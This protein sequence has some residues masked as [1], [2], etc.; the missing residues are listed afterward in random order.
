MRL[1]RFAALLVLATG[2]LDRPLVESSPQTSNEFVSQVEQSAVNK[3][4][5]LFMV[6][7]S[8]SMAD[9][10]EILQSAVPV[11]V[12]RLTSPLCVDNV[13]GAP[14]GENSSL[15]TCKLGT[16]EFQPVTDIHVGIVTSSLGAHGG[17]V[18]PAAAGNTPNDRA[19][20][21]PTVRAAGSNAD[22]T[23]T[24]DV[25]N[26]WNN[27][28]FLAWDESQH[29]VP[30][31]T[32]DADVFKGKFQD[33]IAASGEHGCG[34][35]ASLE[36]WYRFLIDPE[37]PLNVSTTTTLPEQTVR[38]SSLV[39]NPDGSTTCNGCDLEL[40]AQRKAFL[41]PDSLV[42]IVMLSDEN[43]CSM[44]DDGSA[45]FVATQTD[46]KGLPVRMPKASAACATDPNDP[47]CRS[48]VSGET[49][50]PK[51][52]SALSEDAVCKNVPAGQRYATWDK[53]GDSINLR[54]FQQM[55]RF[56]FDLLYPTSRY[57]D[58][59]TKPM[60]TLQ[61]DGKTSVPNPLY[62][63][64]PG[65]G[66]RDAS[67]VFLAGIV[68]V[69]WQDIA[70]DASLK[71]PGLKYLSANELVAKDRWAVLLGDPAARPPAPPADPFMV[72]STA[73]RSGM[74]PITHDAIVPASATSPTASPINGHEQN[75][76]LADDLQYACTFA[77]QTPKVCPAGDTACDCAASP[78]GDAS[79]VILANSPLC[80]PAAGGAATSEQRFAKAYPGTRELQVLKGLNDHGI[81]A[82]I[83]PK[84]TAS[85]DPA[86]DPNYG[87]NPAV[88]A[89]IDRLKSALVGTCLPRPLQAD[90]QTHQVL[91]KV[92]EAQPAGAT[93]NCKAPGRAPVDSQI[94]PAVQRELR[95]D[96]HC[97]NPGQPL[98]A[99][100]CQCEILQESSGPALD[101]CRLGLP[102]PAGSPP[103]YC[104][105]DDP[106]SPAV[107]HCAPN[108][109]R[110]LQFVSVG[111]QQTPASGAVAVV[112]CLGA[113]VVDGGS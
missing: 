88:A 73:A 34:Y 111:E 15:G 69:P 79:A 21:L 20:L 98:C 47:C 108:Q 72:E 75:V 112:T 59:L 23:L 40:L 78:K 56:G 60:L 29:D 26:T 27:A 92:I 68:G 8:S 104:Y 54:C 37:P 66:P 32:A 35:E 113:S 38:G 5:L 80:Q 103:G 77:L 18:C 25:S 67:R 84:V 31:G 86:S 87:Y 46:A 10:Q 16:P 93:C 3:I 70:D 63:A 55:K 48:C 91:C 7:N 4:D 105:I 51:G 14:T 45:W 71:G 11:L 6:D 30:P 94:V 49:A 97:G 33:M 101:A 90:P 96:G 50:P 106:A 52:C 13:T 76:P 65:V 58:A 81:V 53:N 83:C 19:H 85:A 28:G 22:P 100:F 2:C 9:K 74:N 42:A 64:A 82:S 99:S 89:I 24:F 17:D 39:T 12:K 102:A 62:A 110:K 57:V 36:A 44:R 41:R 95:A 1:F 43:D 107:K 109:K 61:S